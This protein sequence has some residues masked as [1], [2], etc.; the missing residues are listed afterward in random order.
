[1]NDSVGQNGPAKK[2]CWTLTII[3]GKFNLQF[4]VVP[5]SV[6][7]SI[8]IATV[9]PHCKR[10]CDIIVNV[11]DFGCHSSF[12]HYR[13]TILSPVYENFLLTVETFRIGL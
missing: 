1:M 3:F 13:I 12:L 8:R 10:R 7:K 5:I 6:N 11:T 9:V 2:N 4:H